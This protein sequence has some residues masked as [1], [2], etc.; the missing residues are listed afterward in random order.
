MTDDLRHDTAPSTRRDHGAQQGEPIIDARNVAVDIAVEDGTVNAVRDVS[1]QLYRGETIAIV[2]ESGSG[3]SVTARTVMGLLPKRASVGK[4]ATINYNGEDVLKFSERRR[5]D[6]RG[7]RISMIFQE[8]MSSLNPIYTIGS[9]II[10]AIQTHRRVSRKDAEVETLELLK[11]VQIPEPEARLKQYPHQ[12]S[13]GQRQRVMIAM[14]LANKPDVLIADEPT[15]ALDVTVQAQILK[16]I[17]A[18]RA[19]HGLSVLLI[20]HNIAV[21]DE[22]CDRA[23]VMQAGR[24]VEQGPVP[25][26]L[27]APREAYTKRLLAAEPTLA[28]IGRS[29]HG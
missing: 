15:T 23:V 17:L 9:Q 20:T 1:F 16:L 18:M 11:Q 4:G 19:E 2:G 25:Q 7:S 14:A 5:R 3:K 26:L 28:R 6:M 21:V 24:V 22:I 29:R 13:G 10:E 8:P 27:D 12:L